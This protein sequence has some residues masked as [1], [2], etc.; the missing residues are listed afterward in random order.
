MHGHPALRNVNHRL[1]TSGSVRGQNCCYHCTHSYADKFLVGLYG[2][3]NRKAVARVVD[4]GSEP[5]F[6]GQ[7]CCDL[8][9][10]REGT[11]K[12]TR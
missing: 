12:E 9:E 11:W 2:C 1:V 10:R 6:P 5:L 8:F 4:K 3:T 7:H